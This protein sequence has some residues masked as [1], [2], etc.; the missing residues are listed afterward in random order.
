MKKSFPVIITLITL[1]LLGIIVLQVSWFR[2]MTK[3]RQ[4]QLLEKAEEAGTKVA[5]ELSRSASH[6]PY[7]KIPHKQKLSLLGDDYQIPLGKSLLSDHFS[8]FEI[9]EKLKQAFDESGL[10]DVN[11]EFGITYNSSNYLLE[12]QS[13]NFLNVVSDTV[14]NKNVIIAIVPQEYTDLK[15]AFEHLIIIIP[16]LIFF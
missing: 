6:A 8:P 15:D 2:D 5:I 16:I 9:R 10:K 3:L 13:Q 4:Q 14:H 12:L 11:F 1:S 7:M